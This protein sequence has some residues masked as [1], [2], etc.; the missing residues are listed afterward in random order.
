MFPLYD[1]LRSRRFPLV[2]W[3]LIGLNG[4]T[5]YYELTLGQEGLYRFI[6]TW[7]LVPVR[8]TASP[9]ESWITIFSSMFIHGGWRWAKAMHQ[10]SY[11]NSVCSKLRTY[12]R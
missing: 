12:Q 8:L 4:I 11:S 10:M 6:Q 3:L 5:F 1:T 9:T 7:G 2:N